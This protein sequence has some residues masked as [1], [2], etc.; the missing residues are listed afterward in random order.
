LKKLENKVALVTGSG[1]GLGR[2]IAY[3]FAREGAKVMLND[4]NEQLLKQTATEMQNDYDVDYIVADV[5]KKEEVVKMVDQVVARFGNINILVNNAGG[6]LHTPRVLEDIEE[7]QW[8]KVLD[9]NLKG[10]FLTSQA[11]VK[12]MKKSGSGKIINMA[13]VAGRY[14]SVSTGVAYGAAK[15]G[16][17]SFTRKLGREVGSHSINVNALAPGVVISGER[18]RNSFYEQKTE[19]ERNY[20]IS[21]IALG[22]LGELED[23]ANAAIFLA[24]E[25]AK[26][27]TGAVIDVNGGLFMG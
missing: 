26:Y 12:Y 7:E 3:G 27:I 9:V 15:G 13:S 2:A 21:Q 22:T 24:S 6:S 25:D 8:D 18:I 1:G 17:I 23:I 10:T 19:K 14:G 4:V 20:M 5:S 16:I 11:A